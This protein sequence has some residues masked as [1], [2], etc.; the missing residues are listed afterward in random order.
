MKAFYVFA[1]SAGLWAQEGSGPKPPV[2]EQLVVGTY[3]QTDNLEAA[4]LMRAN[5]EIARISEAEKPLNDQLQALEKSKGPWQAEMTARIAAL[6]KAAKVPEESI[7][8]NE[9]TAR[10]AR[11]K[12]GKDVLEIVWEKKKK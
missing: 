4:N 7:K 12:D 1:V 9:C 6:C 3:S 11:D 2:T 5:A 8:A 10:V